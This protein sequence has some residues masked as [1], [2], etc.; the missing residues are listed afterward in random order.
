MTSEELMELLLRRGSKYYKHQMR[1]NC[2]MI[3]TKLD[4]KK[5]VEINGETYSCWNEFI[6]VCVANLIH[7]EVPGINFMV[8]LDGNNSTV[9]MEIDNQEE[10]KLLEIAK[11]FEEAGI[12]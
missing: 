10:M 7:A 1:V 12:E 8:N 2:P 3:S 6:V 9:E 5:P 11:K 4:M